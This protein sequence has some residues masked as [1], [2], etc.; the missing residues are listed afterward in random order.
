MPTAP[1]IVSLVE[2]AL[3]NRIKARFGNALRKVDSLPGDLDEALLKQI[4]VQAP[5]VYILF[6]G[7]PRRNAENSN[8]I[9]GKWV[10]FAIT[11]HASGQAAR[12]RGD[13]LMIGAYQIISIICGSL[14]GYVVDDVGTL[15]LV[16]VQNLFNGAIDRQGCSIYA[17]TF[18]LPMSFT[19]V[20]DPALLDDFVTFH[21]D[22]DFAPQD[23]VNDATDQVTLEQV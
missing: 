17:A 8:D 13:A 19:P 10:I 22:Y 3:I 1:D 18:N 21:A 11:G 6:S 16:N 9:D 15:E 7:G 5:G 12:R 4:L 2:D 14:S 20:L 23:G